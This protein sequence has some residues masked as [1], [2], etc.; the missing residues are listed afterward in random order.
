MAHP[1]EIVYVP[2]GWKLDL[3]F[4]MNLNRSVVTPRSR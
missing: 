2:A 3:K 4:E 1:G